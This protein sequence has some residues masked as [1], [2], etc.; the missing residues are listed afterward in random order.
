MRARVNDAYPSL[1]EF[2]TQLHQ[3][4]ELSFHEEQSAARVA[5]E[6]RQFGC[7]VTTG[8]GGF[9]VVAVLRNGSGP[10]ILVR[11]DMD[12]LPVKEQTGLPYASTAVA[13]EADGKDVPVMHAC[14]H[15]AHMTSLIGAARVLAGL[16]DQW[17]GTII[18]IGQPAEEAG[19]GARRMLADGL[20]TRFPR[21]DF[22]L[23]LHVSSDLPAGS[24]GY[25]EGYAL[26]NIDTIELTLRGLGGHGAFPQ[27]TKDP[28][29]LAAQTILALQ[30]IVSREVTPGD[31][32]VVTVGSIHGGAKSNIIPDE[33]RLQLTLRSY[34]EEVRRQTLDAVQRIARGQAL[35]DGMPEDRLPIVRVGEDPIRATYNN[36]ALTQRLAG[37]LSRK[38]VV[39]ESSLLE[40]GPWFA[41]V[42]LLVLVAEW[43]LRRRVNL[44]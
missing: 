14:G 41:V 32:A 42:F 12:A 30:T 22:C 10:T 25:S 19:A 39:T 37:K 23:A 1:F 11:S 8:I 27:T 4:P 21:P 18:F 28:I 7:E 5:Q 3:H 20:F 26:A 6:L 35:S 43:T 16:K 9:G 38:S 34:T 33:V 24:L 2:Y 40:A 13:K 15:D 36:P 31:P 29:V 17:Q 44:F